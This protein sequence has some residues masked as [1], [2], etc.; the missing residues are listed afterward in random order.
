MPAINGRRQRHLSTNR[1]I[2]APRTWSRSAHK[3]GIDLIYRRDVEIRLVIVLA[4]LDARIATEEEPDDEQEKP[5]DRGDVEPA[6]LVDDSALEVGGCLAQQV[7]EDRPS[8]TNNPIS[9]AETGK[10]TGWTRRPL[11]F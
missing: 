10:T 4:E 3:H 7:A 11:I 6:E 1:R 5:R 9:V 8:T 2:H